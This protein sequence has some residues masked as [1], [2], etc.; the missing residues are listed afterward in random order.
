M[1]LKLGQYSQPSSGFWK[2]VTF[3]YRV[4]FF[5]TV[6]LYY[7]IAEKTCLWIGTLQCYAQEKNSHHPATQKTGYIPLGL[8]LFVLE[9]IFKIEDWI[10]GTSWMENRRHRC[11][12]ERQQ[13]K[14]RCR[15]RLCFENMK[16]RYMTA[17]LDKPLP[18]KVL[19]SWC[20]QDINLW[21]VFI[22]K[23]VICIL[24]NKQVR[25]T[26]Y[27]IQVYHVVKRTHKTSYFILNPKTKGLL[28]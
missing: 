9:H 3:L 13:R 19:S 21:S 5:K 11:N 4:G 10:F 26:L 23:Q 12:L 15:S 20:S 25:H 7:S 16:E 28:T 6:H 8:E 17:V 14:P 24:S 1:S 27:L 2:A 18:G 22:H